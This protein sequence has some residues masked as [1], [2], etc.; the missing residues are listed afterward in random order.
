MNLYGPVYPSPFGPW[1]M[2]Q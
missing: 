1:T 2:D